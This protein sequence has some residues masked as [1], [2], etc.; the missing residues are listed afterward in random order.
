MNSGL[1]GSAGYGEN[2][3]STST[4]FAGSNDDGTVQVDVTSVFGAGGISFF[5]ASH[6]E[7][8]INSNGAITFGASDNSY[9][10]AGPND[11]SVPT[12]LPFYSDIN[13][14]NGGEIYWDIDPA[15]GK[16]TI[17]WDQV[18]PFSGTGTNSF[19]V[20]LT[21]LGGG[22]MGVEYIYG[23]IQWGDSGGNPAYA[24][25][26]DGG[27]IDYALEN[28]GNSTAMEAYESNDF[29]NGDPSGT[30]SFSTSGGVP[31]LL[32]T[33]GTSGNDTMGLGFI[34][35]TGN[36]ITTDADL[37]DGGAGDDSIDGDTGNDTILGGAGN[38]TILSGSTG[39]GGGGP[40]WTNVA[41]GQT[42]TGTS[43]QDYFRFTGGA[44]TT[45]QVRF[46][47]GAG[48]RDADGQ[49][50]Y[51]HVA[52][53]AD[54]IQLSI[55]DFEMFTDKIVLS[56]DFAVFSQSVS[57]SFGARTAVMG[58]R[59]SNG[60]EQ[61][62]T[63]RL[64]GNVFDS[65]EV[66][67]TTLPGAGVADDDLLDGGDDADTFVVED[68]FGADTIVGGEGGTDDDTIDLSAVTAPVEV[69]LGSSETGTITD[70]ADTLSYSEIEALTLTSGDD[71][72]SLAGGPNGVS[73]IE[74]D[75]GAGNDS[76]LTGYGN[77]SITAGDGNDTIY[78][79]RGDDTVH[80]GAGDDR[81]ET[82][83]GADLVFGG[84]GNDS[85]Y[86]FSELAPWNNPNV[87]LYGEA[88][89]DLIMGSNGQQLLDGGDGNDYI[90]G[91]E[92]FASADR[93]T[94]IGGAGN[95]TLISGNIEAPSAG[96]EGNGDLMQGGTGD[97][98]IEGGSANETMEG[99]DDA[100]TFAVLDNFGTDIITG[101]AGGTDD[102]TIDL[103]ALTGPVTV[104]YTGNE[105]GTIVSGA[106]TI[107][108]SEIEHIVLTN[109]ADSI[110]A[111]AETVDISLDGAG[112]N[113]TLTTGTGDDTVFGGAG[114]DLIDGGS[115][116]DTIVGG[117]D[118][119]V[120]VG[121]EGD[122]SL[123]GGEGGDSLVGGNGA[124][125]LIGEGGIDTLAGGAGADS[126]SGGNDRDT[127]IIEDGFG[128]DTIV[129]GEG[130][131]D[132]DTIDLNA[133]TGPVTV[134]YTGDEAGTITDGTDTIT[135][136]EIE[137]LI[138]TDQNDSV[139]ALADG[140]GVDIDAGA[141]NDTFEGGTGDD[142]VLGG[143]GDD[144]LDG[145][146]GNNT[147]L[148]GD[149]N[150][151]LNASSGTDSIDGGADNDSLFAGTGTSTL[152]GGAG[153][154]FIEI[155]TDDGTSTII[156]GAGTDTV[157]FDS[158][159]GSGIDVSFT[160]D[161]AGT[162]NSADGATGSFSEIEHIDGTGQTDTIDASADTAGISIDAQGGN[163]TVTGGTGD[164]TLDGGTGDDVITGGAGDDV[165]VYNAG[166]GH[167]TITDFNFGN[168]GTLS[169]GDTTNNDFIDL[170]AFYDN[171][172]ELY[173]DQA[174]DGILNQSNDGVDGVDYANNASFGSGSLTFTGASADNTSFTAENTGVVCFASGTAIR[175]PLGE[176]MVETLRAGDLVTT[177]DQG[178]SKVLWIG[179]TE[180]V[181]QSGQVDPRRTPVRIKPDVA[182]GARALLVSPQ[183]CMMMTDATGRPVLARARHLAEETRLAAFARGR[184]TVTY[185]HVLLERHS[186]LISQ[187][188]P[189]ES[190][191]PGPNGLAMMATTERARLF[192]ALPALRTAPVETAYGPRALKVLT[193]SEV[194][195]NARTDVFSFA[196]PHDLTMLWPSEHRSKFVVV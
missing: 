151:H 174:D 62:F 20:V 134:T 34:D 141:G 95:D 52:S 57:G 153:D 116:N 77:D 157:D 191:Y 46:N 45:G 22:E 167:D 105:A 24:G 40:A 99:G 90:F 74:I 23:D 49:A 132:D 149:G 120:L 170:S 4:K 118:R 111:A 180:V 113:D 142:S 78:A 175:T 54:G 50:D 7:I 89:D 93:D 169:D 119:D 56:A 76:I 128:A 117:L 126:L 65:S 104:N 98:Y 8:Y 53:T 2:T 152:D 6:T 108:F 192:K 176:V 44:G 51:L 92:D 183:H 60:N 9:D 36:A 39:A 182:S 94:L 69:S 85:L 138:L 42:A 135:F 154:D 156:G 70:G 125:T 159:S 21:D 64:V 179:C 37:I 79:G 190:Y 144:R 168:T 80:A 150:D 181:L 1:G 30:F 185:W 143:A 91:G 133:L 96:R 100:D 122:D 82:D 195:R 15:N 88:G 187:G 71:T 67:T 11:F 188:R 129:G 14:G 33:S 106:D 161:G 158:G 109:N 5:G 146:G 63:I 101:G 147:L 177:Q 145:N 13:I 114:N 75:A 166:D 123:N 17:T 55:E 84:D 171:I 3:F 165:F 121:G 115:G 124:D 163:D 86:S 68:S 58:V 160:G 112:G 25:F 173:A 59:L 196:S 47:N 48:I 43:G 18:A 103:S 10:Q 73:D 41:A 38:D 87:T 162:Y 164:D 137:G 131:N 61:F 155:D 184:S 29:D 26:T 110:N 194:R 27:G 107:T 102:D 148:G 189:S 31:D 136:S 186:V 12:L 127:F 178:P 19:Q 139:N 16:I 97:D 130:G 172:G 66:F 35:G 28:S 32:S 72:V 140:A 83:F 193:R 81:V